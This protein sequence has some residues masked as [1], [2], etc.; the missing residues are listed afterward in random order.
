MSG[1]TLTTAHAAT[2]LGASQNG[3]QYTWSKNGY[4][5]TPKVQ[6]VPQLRSEYGNVVRYYNKK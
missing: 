5:S 4:F 1:T 2:Y 6:S 3:T